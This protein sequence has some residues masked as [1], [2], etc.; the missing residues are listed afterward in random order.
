MNVQWWIYTRELRNGNGC[1]SWIWNTNHGS[2]GFLE[3]YSSG[4]FWHFGRNE[5]LNWPHM[6]PSGVPWN[7][8]YICSR[9]L[10][11][12]SVTLWNCWSVKLP[13]HPFPARVSKIGP[14]LASGINL[15]TRMLLCPC[16][17][18]WPIERK[19]YNLH[20]DLDQETSV[21]HSLF[22]K[23]R[24]LF[25]LGIIFQVQW[26]QLFPSELAWLCLS[27]EILLCGSLA[28]WV[29]IFDSPLSCLL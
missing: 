27:R 21:S 23:Q 5:I 4:L 10:Q 25:T 17:H 2:D 11:L 18:R 15:E 29:E 12:C 20:F 26:G 24:G 28:V 9:D 8:S 6:L 3:A 13:G 19:F 22:Q 14:Y 16:E 1:W 7:L